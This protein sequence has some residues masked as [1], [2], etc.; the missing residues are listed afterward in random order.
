M[1][2]ETEKGMLV[3]ALMAAKASMERSKAKATNPR[4]GPIYDEDLRVLAALVM[5]VQALEVSDGKG[6]VAPRP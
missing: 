3:Y 4:F 5:K 2:T 1:F 6:K